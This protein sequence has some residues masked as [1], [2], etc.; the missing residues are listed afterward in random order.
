MLASSR[1]TARLAQSRIHGSRRRLSQT[2]DT[3]VS[4]AS[5]VGATR[6]ALGAS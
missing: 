4:S 2:E 6:L 1:A 5:L 3:L